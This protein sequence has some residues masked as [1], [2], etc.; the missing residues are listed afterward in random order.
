MRK[1]A[2]SLL[3]SMAV[4]GLYLI[5]IDLASSFDFR[6]FHSGGSTTSDPSSTT[7][8]SF[9]PSF[10]SGGASDPGVR[11][12]AAGAGDPLPGLTAGQLEY[13]NSGKAEFAAAEGVADG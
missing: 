5:Q 3:F 12:G 2:A 1:I 13:F 11:G 6:R 9:S 8:Q 10:T 4:I 7:T